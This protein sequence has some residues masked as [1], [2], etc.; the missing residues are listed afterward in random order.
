[1][2]QKKRQQRRKSASVR[3]KQTVWQPLTVRL[4]W[5]VHRAFSGI[6]T[7]LKDNDSQRPAQEVKRLGWSLLEKWIPSSCVYL[8]TLTGYICSGYLISK[9]SITS[10]SFPLRYR[11]DCEM[12]NRSVMWRVQATRSCRLWES[13]TKKKKK[14]AVQHSCSFIRNQSNDC[15]EGKRVKR[16]C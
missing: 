8:A 13:N 15:L 5:T 10:S 7:T 1:M 16:Y 12:I 14:Q 3:E 2:R 6:Y 4:T 9:A 11:S